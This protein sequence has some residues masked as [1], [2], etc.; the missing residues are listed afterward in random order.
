MEQEIINKINQ[1]INNFRL[2]RYNQLPVIELYIDQVVKIIETTLEPLRSNKEQVWITTSM[3]NNYTKQGLIKSQIKKRYEREHVA[4]L[5]YICLTKSVMQISNIKELIRSQKE[6]Y[7]SEIAYDFF[8]TKLENSLQKVFI[9]TEPQPLEVSEQT[10]QIFLLEATV[11]TIAQ[12][13]YLNKYL[14][15]LSQRNKAAT[16]TTAE[17]QN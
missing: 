1:Q 4:Y 5:I 7:E 6:K 2:P 12:Q 13:I 8:C 9:Q 17:K 3:I 10:E 16:K 15:I 11:D 14:E